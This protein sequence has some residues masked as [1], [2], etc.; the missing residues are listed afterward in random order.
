MKLPDSGLADE[1][2]QDLIREY[3]E[4]IGGSL[5]DRLSRDAIGKLR[6]WVASETDKVRRDFLLSE[7][8]SLL[9]VCGPRDEVLA[10][11]RE[12]QRSKPDDP[13]GW[14]HLSNWFCDPRYEDDAE[15]YSLP[16]AL[17]AIDAAIEKAR[18]TGVYLRLCLHHRCRIAKSMKRY[19]LL[20]DSM[21][22]ILSLPP[23]RGVT[24]ET[25]MGDFLRGIP[26][27][28]VDAAVL[29]DYRDQLARKEAY[30]KR[31]NAERAAAARAVGEAPAGEGAGAA[32]QD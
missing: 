7:L 27:G 16:E 9:R 22:Q 13:W 8:Y 4:R 17:R 3:E 20:E 32:G 6:E 12:I 18:V 2:D 14:I 19:D 25:I 10:T 26:E 15:T 11:I 31:K 24:D 23:G 1:E 21:R 28:A 29:A 5:A 30:W